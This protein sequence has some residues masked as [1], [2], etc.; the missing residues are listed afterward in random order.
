[1]SYVHERLLHVKL[2]PCED[3]CIYRWCSSLDEIKIPL[4]TC[5]LRATPLPGHIIILRCTAHGIEPCHETIA[6]VEH[7]RNEGQQCITVTKER[8]QENM[9]GD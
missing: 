3:R 1:M 5:P 7:L 4:Y 8:K 2:V 6:I 9:E